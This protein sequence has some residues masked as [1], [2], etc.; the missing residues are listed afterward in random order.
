MAKTQKENN[1]I[2]SQMSKTN[3]DELL[4]NKDYR[5]AFSLLIMVLER[6]DNN[7]KVELIDYYTKHLDDLYELNGFESHLE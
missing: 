4:Y 7:E 6:L 5:K 3:I 2:Y 1:K